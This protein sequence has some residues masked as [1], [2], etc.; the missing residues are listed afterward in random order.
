MAGKRYLVTGAA[1]FIGFHLAKALLERGDE[2][3]GY[4]NVND[5]YSP[6]LK[7]ERTKILEQYEQYT[8]IKADLKD[9]ETLKQ[10]VEN[11]QIDFIIHL[12]AQAGVRYSITHP[13]TYIDS[14]IIGMFNVL[15]VCRHCHV[16]L[17]YASSSSVYGNNE[18]VLLD[19]TLQVDAPVSLYAAT[20]KSNELFAHAYT[21]NYKFNAIGLRFFTV[22]GPYGR[23]DMAY[24]T[25]TQ[26]ILRGETIQVYNYGNQYR[27]F[28]Y[29][30]DV[31]QGI[32]KLIERQE[33]EEQHGVYE[34]FNIGNGNPT[35]LMD[36]IST[37]EEVIGKKAHL[38]FTER[39]VG[40]VDKT[41]ADVSKLK[42]YTGYAPST[43]IKEGIQRFYDWYQVYREKEQ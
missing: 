10:V 38:E 11:H 1:G 20:K 37:I 27:D 43:N 31:V 17:I 16:Q 2:V 9:Y 22:Y 4:D 6:F 14:N 35:K 36:F 41:Y 29:I 28:T 42:A 40:D 3:I 39:A 34:I 21:N 13:G 33:K 15:E 19:E 25:F 12:G 23:P 18:N 5:Y 32:I 30:D 26:K 8:F 7:M 24:Y